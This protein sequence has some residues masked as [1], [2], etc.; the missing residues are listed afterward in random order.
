MRRNENPVVAALK[1]IA[2][3]RGFSIA[4]HN[5]VR[6]QAAFFERI[7]PV[8]TQFELIRI[9]GEDDGGYLVPDDLDGLT[10]CY[11]PGVNVTA[12]F[13]EDMLA[14]GLPCYLLDASVAAPPIEHPLIDFEPKFLA[15]HTDGDA[16]ITLDDWVARKTPGATGDLILQMDI[17]GAEWPV[18]LNAS[19]S[20]LSA[21]RIL[22]IEFHWGERIFDPFGFKIISGVFDRLHRLFDIVHLH[23]NNHMGIVRSQNFAI[24]HAFEATFLRKGRGT[25]QGLATQFPHPLDRDCVSRY[26][27]LVLP[28]CMHG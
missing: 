27:H 4:R 12:T 13:E 15:A 26:P 8:R 28:D 10:A 22:V 19:E 23:P 24:P 3:G 21:F 20:V 18:L 16:L 7:K 17:E 1:D 14:R 25:V 5:P 2:F 9:G 6:E 11:S